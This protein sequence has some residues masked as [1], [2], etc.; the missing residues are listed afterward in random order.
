[1]P[2]GIHRV[3]TLPDPELGELWESI[4]V[5][6][7]LKEQLLAQA[8]LNFVIRTK[9]NRSVLPLH[10][11]ILLFGPPGTGKTS[12]ALGAAHRTAASL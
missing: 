9:V 5:D 7:A 6:T 3:R 2:K 8:V 10:G 11:V 12:L 1:M 4:V